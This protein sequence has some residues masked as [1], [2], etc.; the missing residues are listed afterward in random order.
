[1]LGLADMPGKY[2]KLYA[3][4]FAAPVDLWMMLM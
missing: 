1:M 2:S 4:N 3:D